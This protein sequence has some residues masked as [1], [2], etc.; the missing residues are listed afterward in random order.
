MKHITGNTYTT[1]IGYTDIGIYVDGNSAI[2]I[3]TG[4][5]ETPALLSMLKRHHLTP[6]AILNPHLHIDHIGCN[7]LLQDTFECPIFCPLD[8][9]ED[10]RYDAG[11]V[12]PDTPIGPCTMISLPGHSIAHQA[13]VTPDGVCFLGD[14]IM[15]TYS[16]MPYYQNVGE[17]LDSMKKILDLSYPYFV[18][19]HAGVHDMDETHQIAM[20]NITKECDRLDNILALCNRKIKTEKLAT[21]FMDSIHISRQTQDI[22]WVTDTAKAR[23]QELARQGCISLPHNQVK[24]FFCKCDY[25][26]ACKSQESIG[27]LR[28]IVGL[29]RESHLHDSKSQQYQTDCSYQAEDKV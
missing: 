10:A 9:I 20:D 28:W 13:V 11:V 15:S 26:S 17:A 14:A 29:K 8:E 21:L 7:K 1:R 3:D 25:D 27:P 22:F 2:L 6:K 23:I 18:L 24:D 12:S 5:E 4:S 16:K 19:S